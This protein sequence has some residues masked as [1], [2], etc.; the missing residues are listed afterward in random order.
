[1]WR[2][3]LCHKKIASPWY[4][5]QAKESW[6]SK[7]W[8]RP[9]SVLLEE[10]LKE[11]RRLAPPLPSQTLKVIFPCREIQFATEFAWIKIPTDFLSQNPVLWGKL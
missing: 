10:R 1:M 3:A 7:N 2:T 5:E 4:F 6:C 11:V 8:S 9:I